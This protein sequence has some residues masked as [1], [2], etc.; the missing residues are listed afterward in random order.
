[1]LSNY[2]Y[3]KSEEFKEVQKKSLIQKLPEIL[4]RSNRKNLRVKCTD[5]SG[6]RKNNL[7]IQVGD[8]VFI[9]KDINNK[10]DNN[11]IEIFSKNTGE[12]Q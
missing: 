5:L 9:Q 11:A 12:P 6:R 7:N 8:E 4:Q 1:M 2:T 3:K 10:Y